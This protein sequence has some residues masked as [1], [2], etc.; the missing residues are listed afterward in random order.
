MTAMPRSEYPRPRLVR[1]RWLCLNGK[2]EFAFDEEGSLSEESALP[3]EITVPFAHQWALSDLEDRRMSET[4]WYARSFEVPQEWTAGSVLLHFGAV[5]YEATVWINGTE[6]A[7]HRG[8]HVP[9]TVDVASLLRQGENRVVLRVVDPQDPSQPRGKQASSGAPHGIDYWCTTGIWQTVWLEPVAPTYL[10]DLVVTGDL[11]SGALFVTPIVHGSRAELEVVVNAYEGDLHIATASGQPF[12]TEPIRLELPNPRPWSP[13]SPFLYDLR[14]RL[15]RHGEVVD[16]VSSYAGL[17]SIELRDGRFVINGVPTILRLVLDQ[18]YWPE[19]GLT[20][21]SDEALRADVE[22]CKR[23]GFNGAR[24]HQKVEDP[25]WLYWCDRL[26]LFAWG[27]M[28]NARAWSFQ[29]QERV[30]AEWASAVE[31]DRSHPS[32]IA[33]VPLNESMGYPKLEAGDARQISGLQ[34]LV[35]LTRRLDPT[36]PVIDNDGWEQT[37]TS[38]VVAIHDYSH[39]GEKLAGRYVDG[40]LPERIWSGSRIS[41]LP[42]SDAKGKPILLTEVGGFL[43]RPDVPEE[44]LDKM[45]RIYDSIASN[46]QL[47]EKYLELMEGIG[48]VPFLAG[49]C[50]TQLT[51]VEQELNGLLTYDRRLKVDAEAVAAAHER[52]SE[53]LN[54]T[55]V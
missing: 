33:W 17:R 28:A 53:R 19:S 44:E 24:K 40:S 15:V 50:Y 9:F 23:L 31:R 34:R 3:L 16:E 51:D 4:V 6:V 11:G 14:V 37:A 8:G 49:F 38:D 47:L 20:A 10:A 55:K 7:F 21:P 27:E 5:D 46:D 30:E 2:W 54:R 18:G 12:T 41:L 29:A 1:D 22:W 13:G 43:T 32:I 35:H 39:S 48:S 45:Y 25:R 42:G 36:R 52:L 26:G